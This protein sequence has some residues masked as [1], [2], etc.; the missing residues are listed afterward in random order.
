MELTREILNELLEYD[1]ESGNL[2]WKHRD[3]KWF[4]GEMWH[5]TWN[6]RFANKIAGH[7]WQSKTLSHYKKIHIKM[8]DG[9]VHMAHRIIWCMVYG[10]FPKDGY[11]IDHIDGN[12]TNNSL[13]NLRLVTRSDNLK[14]QKRRKD[15]TS[16]VTGVRNN[17]GK[18][19]VE[20]MTSYGRKHIG[21]FVDFEDAVYA[22]K[23]A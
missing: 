4:K 13:K 7:I 8:V 15:N 11:D 16:G 9:R 21:S 22:R 14:N 1:R 17:N 10:D 19:I 18:W 23:K 2:I 5:K 3:I 12:A 20:I 6:T